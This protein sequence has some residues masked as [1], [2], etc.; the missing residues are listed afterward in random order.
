MSFSWSGDVEKEVPLPTQRQMIRSDKA[1]GAAL[2][3][4]EIQRQKTGTG[5]VEEDE[6]D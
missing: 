4:R 6:D 3:E 2:E 5:V 1:L